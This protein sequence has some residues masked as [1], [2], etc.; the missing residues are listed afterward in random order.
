MALSLWWFIV[1]WVKIAKIHHTDYKQ[2]VIEKY[3]NELKGK[4]M[5]HK[6]LNHL[7]KTKNND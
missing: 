5:L 6:D 2:E 1:K 7:T 4:G 3:A